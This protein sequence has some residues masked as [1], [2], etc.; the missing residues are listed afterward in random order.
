MVLRVL[1][2]RTVPCWRAVSVSTLSI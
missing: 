2:V 1:G